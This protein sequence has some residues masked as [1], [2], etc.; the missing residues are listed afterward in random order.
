V[1]T[2]AP[3]LNAKEITITETSSI[4]SKQINVELEKGNVIKVFC[5]ATGIGPTQIRPK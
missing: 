1:S 4:D 3:D 2:L 5:A